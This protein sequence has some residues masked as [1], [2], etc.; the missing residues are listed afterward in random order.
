MENTWKACPCSLLNRFFGLLD[1]AIWNGETSSRFVRNLGGLKVSLS[2]HLS[3]YMN[4]LFWLDILHAL[5][6]E[7]KDFI[8]L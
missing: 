5:S 8:V 2:L 1:D 7:I 4:A 6:E 3:I